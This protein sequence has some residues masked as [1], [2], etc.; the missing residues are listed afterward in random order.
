MV[1]I[2]AHPLQ[3]S[4]NN[5][6]SSISSINGQI[7][8]INS[9]ITTIETNLSTAGSH[10][11]NLYSAKADK[12][13]DYKVINTIPDY[14]NLNNYLTVGSYSV[15]SNASAKTMSNLPLTGNSGTLYVIN[16]L[17]SA[18]TMTKTGYEYFLQIFL[19]YT[20]FIYIRAIQCNSGTMSYGT[21]ISLT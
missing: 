2:G 14:A 13:Y 17:G 21:W 5:L 12:Y 18:D 6:S 20:A 15:T 9:D 1:G 7:S 4:L 11:S 3:N 10:I 16:C 19:G 8:T